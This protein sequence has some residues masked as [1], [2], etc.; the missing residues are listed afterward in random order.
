MLANSNLLAN[1]QVFA[2]SPVGDAL[3]IYGDTVY[4]LYV[5]LQ[6]PF[7]KTKFKGTQSALLPR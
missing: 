4:P 6:A 3:C 5:H 7:R 1:L 2:F